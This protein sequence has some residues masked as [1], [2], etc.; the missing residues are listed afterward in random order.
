MVHYFITLSGKIELA[1]ETPAKEKG[2]VI[3]VSP[4]FN[5]C[6][7]IVDAYRTIYIAPSPEIKAVFDSIRELEAVA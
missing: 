6:L 3:Y 5:A 4:C 7:P 2:L 1:K